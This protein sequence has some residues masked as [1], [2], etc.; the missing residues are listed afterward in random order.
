M[1]M[2]MKSMNLTV[3]E[4]TEA[5]QGFSNFAEFRERFVRPLQLGGPGTRCPTRGYADGPS[6]WHL[7]FGEPQNGETKTK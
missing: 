1:A 7:L 6:F 2:S 3:G 4:K 5:L